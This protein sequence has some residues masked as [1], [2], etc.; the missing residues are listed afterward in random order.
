MLSLLLQGESRGTL[1]SMVHSLSQ[2]GFWYKIF[3]LVCLAPFWWPILKAMFQEINDTLR[4]EGGLL[5]RTPTATEMARLEEKFGKYENPLVS[6]PRRQGGARAAPMKSPGKTSGKNAGKTAGKG[7]RG[8][9]GRGAGSPPTATR[10]R[11]F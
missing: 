9:A 10:R 11:G 8:G 7:Q 3:V 1:D 2:P 6:I 4:D 5:G